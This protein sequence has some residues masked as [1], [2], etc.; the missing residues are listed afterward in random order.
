[1]TPRE[2][3]HPTGRARYLLALRLID[4]ERAVD[5]PG[6]VGAL[7]GLCRSLTTH[8]DMLGVAVSLTSGRGSAGVVAASDEHCRQLDEL[9]FA[10]GEGP[11][12]DSVLGG[13]PVLTPD[14]SAVGTR[15]WPGYAATAVAVGVTGVF[16]FPLQ[17]GAVC[18]GVLNVYADRPG[19]LTQE[20]LQMTLTFA[21]I[22]TEILLDGD[23]LRGGELEPGLG[24]ALA[25]R[26]E[27]YQA[28][29]MLMVALELGAAEA[30]AR[31]RAHAFARDLTLLALALE[32]LA[33]EA[34]LGDK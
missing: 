29:G 5:V 34:R 22:A 21:R 11:S 31:M 8:L 30:L 16:A 13:R 28:Q 24:D 18:L 17:V 6:A 19:S 7:Q 12:Y 33:G 9:Q 27:I 4:A 23:L 32:I 14:L 10:A 1:M 3:A 15:Q 20:R 25:H 26:A 2:E